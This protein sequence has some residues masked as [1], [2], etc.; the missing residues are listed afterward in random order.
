M[1]RLAEARA[2]EEEVPERR[3]RVLGDKHPETLRT[4][5]YEQPRRDRPMVGRGSRRGMELNRQVFEATMRV[6]GDEH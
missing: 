4:A 1:E 6:I 3:R 5:D 2:V